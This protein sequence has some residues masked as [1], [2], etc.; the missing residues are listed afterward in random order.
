MG[1]WP[2]RTGRSPVTRMSGVEPPIQAKTISDSPHAAGV[3]WKIYT[4]LPS[5]YTY[6]SA[7]AGF[8]DRFGRTGNVV[9]DPTFSQFIADTQSGNLPSVVFLE[10]P[11][12]DEKPDGHRATNIQDGVTEARQL[13]NAGMYGLSWKDSAVIFTDRQRLNIFCLGLRPSY[14]R[15]C[16]PS[17]NFSPAATLNGD[18]YCPV[19]VK[20]AG[21][22]TPA[23]EAAML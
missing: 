16:Q 21:F 8:M 11:D 4:Q 20:T 5:G 15:R 22:V 10:K 17:H 7:F 9:T 6:A 2:V 1:L 3:S 14:A 23:A 13:I 19:S 18:Y 12:P